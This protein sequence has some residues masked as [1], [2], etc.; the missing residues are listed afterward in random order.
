MLLHLVFSTISLAAAVAWCVAV[1][2]LSLWWLLLLLPA[3]YLGAV[4]IYVLAVLV[5]PALFLP[6][7]EEPSH[8]PFY[9][10]IAY[11][12][13][14]WLVGI[15]GYRITVCGAEKLP[16]EPFLLVCNHRSA[17]DP[18]ITIAGLKNRR[19]LTFVSKPE[20]LRVPVLGRLMLHASFLPID[21]DHPRRAIETIRRAARYMQERGLSM[22]IYPE[23]TRNKNEGLLPF[24]NGVFKI[25]K[26]AGTP[27]AVCTIRYNGRRVRLQVAAILDKEFVSA[28]PNAVIGEQVRSIME[29][30]LNEGC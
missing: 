19:Y 23:G 15:L 30:S 12:T 16:A 1:P 5:V 24:H 10:P 9:R 29:D 4:L 27:I 2:T 7:Q 25:A 6:K 8:K 22:G 13:L 17:F 28:S 20:V 21:R 14:V 3:G 26:Q 11:H 18:L